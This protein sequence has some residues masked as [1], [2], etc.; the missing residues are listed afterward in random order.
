MLFEIRDYHY[1]PDLFEAYLLWAEKAVP[2]LRAHMDVLG[3]WVDQGIPPEITGSQPFESPIGSANVTW[4]LRWPDLEAR[5]T[6]FRDTL[7]SP[8][9]KAVW[10]EHPDPGGYLQMS[11][12][13]MKAM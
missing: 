4:I 5:A 1:R 12:R 9:W 6:G 10:A 2:V 8:E 7:A 11:G 3:F 13:F